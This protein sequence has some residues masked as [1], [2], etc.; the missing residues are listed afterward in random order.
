MKELLDEYIIP[1]KRLI[2]SEKK[3][4][5]LV[6]QPE[7]LIIALGRSDTI[8]NSVE[9]DEAN[10]INVK[11]IKRPSGGHTVVLSPKTIVVSIIFTNKDLN[12]KKIFK[13]ANKLITAS[14][15]ELGVKEINEKGISDLCIKDKKILGSSI[16]KKADKVLYHAVINH[17][18]DI[19]LI[20]KLLKHPRKEPEYRA[21]RSHKDFVTSIKNEG[22]NFTIFDFKNTLNNKLSEYEKIYTNSFYSIG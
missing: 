18:E 22:Y 11:I 17:S 2:E 12:T 21:G 4:D 1:D 3:F 13:T 8:E 15:E 9:I 7:K 10:K 20:Q 19:I 16:Y 6:W 5:Y 14:L